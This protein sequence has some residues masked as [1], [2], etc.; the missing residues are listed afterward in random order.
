MNFIFLTSLICFSLESF[1]CVKNKNF[2]HKIA[3]DDNSKG[4]LTIKL[5]KISTKTS[6]DFYDFITRSQTVLLSKK[7]NEKDNL[8]TNSFSEISPDSSDYP[9]WSLREIP[10]YNYRNTQVKQNILS[11][12]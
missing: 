10:V 3:I 1:N 8:T 5:K 9:V 4:F 6:K 2:L 11:I 7:N 12:N